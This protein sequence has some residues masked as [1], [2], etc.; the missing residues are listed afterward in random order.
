MWGWGRTSMPWS[1]RN[2]AGPIWSKKMNGPT[3]CRL[4]DGRARRTVISPRSTARGTIRVSIAPTDARSPSTGS[5]QGLQLIGRLR[6][7]LSRTLRGSGGEQGAAAEQVETG[8]AVHLPLQ[9]LEA[10]DLAFGLAVA[11][12][13][14]ERRPHGGPVLLQAGRERL[15]GPHAGRAG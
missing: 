4:V 12:R 1:V 5:G 10:R 6:S 8:A 13:R 15:H 2:A 9:Q 14:R 3:I 11:P 7:W